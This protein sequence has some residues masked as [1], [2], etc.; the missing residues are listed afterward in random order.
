MQMFASEA[1]NSH[2]GTKRTSFFPV[3]SLTVPQD[4][5]HHGQS[6]D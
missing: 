6:F 4:I 5:V 1:Q 3:A 2:P